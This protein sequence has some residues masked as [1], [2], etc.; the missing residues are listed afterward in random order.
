[1][2]PVFDI[3]I[4]YEDYKELKKDSDQLADIKTI[5]TTK[6]PDEDCYLLAI[7]SILGI[8]PDPEQDVEEPTEIEPE[9]EP[10]ETT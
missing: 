4:P 3:R 7:K 8:S 1:M 10:Q 9:Q 5:L 2:S 6:F